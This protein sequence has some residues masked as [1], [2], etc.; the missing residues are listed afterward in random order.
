MIRSDFDRKMARWRRRGC[1]CRQ[2]ELSYTTVS[3]ASTSAVPIGEP[4]PVTAS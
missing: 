2:D 1:R 4:Q 3:S